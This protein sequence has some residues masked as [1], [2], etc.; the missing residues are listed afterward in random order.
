MW[1]G[2]WQRLYKGVENQIKLENESKALKRQEVVQKAS[3]LAAAFA[4]LKTA[5]D[6]AKDNVWILLLFI[7]KV[8]TALNDTFDELK[9]P[10]DNIGEDDTL[11]ALINN[12]NFGVKMATAK[13]KWKR[14]AVW[15]LLEAI[16]D[17]S[18]MKVKGYI[19]NITAYDQNTDVT[20]PDIW[21][22]TVDGFAA[23]AP[24]N[25]DTTPDEKG[26]GSSWGSHIG[27]TA[28]NEW[29]TWVNNSILDP[30]LSTF[31]NFNRWKT[32]AEGKILL[33]DQAC[34]T[35][36]INAQGAI[37]TMTN[38]TA[39]DKFINQFKNKLKNL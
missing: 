25:A 24:T 30:W 10:L 2:F 38:V 29:K 27:N 33:S 20:N 17:D 18:S 14:K 36:S 5:I 15:K 6:N 7:N 35:I 13:K 3:A 28:K 37:E 21:S 22:E 32:G 4:D 34:K 9:L 23:K 39:S 8:K 11:D 19:I 1:D 12:I 31:S 26:F 16:K